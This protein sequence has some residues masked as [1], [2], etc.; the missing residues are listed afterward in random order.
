[1]SVYIMSTCDI[2]FGLYTSSLKPYFI[3]CGHTFC[4]TCLKGLVKGKI[5]TCAQCRKEFPADFSKFKVNYALINNEEVKANMPDVKAKCI[6]L[7]NDIQKLEEISSSLDR[8]EE[9]Y[10]S[11]CN[12]SENELNSCIESLVHALGNTKTQL[13]HKIEN[14]RN[15]NN[16]KLS[17]IKK[18]NQ[19]SI[20]TR[21]KVLKALMESE[22][23]RAP[24]DS[25][26]TIDLNI[27]KDI[28]PISLNLQKVEYD[29]LITLMSSN[30]SENLTKNLVIS[31]VQLLLGVGVNRNEYQSSIIRTDIEDRGSSYAPSN[32][33]DNFRPNWA[34]MSES[35]SNSNQDLRAQRGNRRYGRG[36][37]NNRRP[38]GS[39]INEGGHSD[40]GS[41]QN[42]DEVENQSDI[43]APDSRRV[44]NQRYRGRHSEPRGNYRGTNE[45][46]GYHEQRGYHEPRGHH[47]SRGRPESRG[48][49]VVEENKIQIPP[50]AFDEVPEE[51]AEHIWFIRLGP[52]Q[53]RLP[54]WVCSQINRFGKKHKVVRI[55]KDNKVVNI[56]DLNNMK[57]F[58]V[59]EMGQKSGHVHDLIGN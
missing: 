13:L 48:Q 45:P 39:N 7:Q 40:A 17:Q 34:D 18:D 28:K 53:R 4:E 8:T 51:N 35:S 58:Q 31:E 23:I 16:R 54:N 1:M 36:R 38:R 33:V 50:R 27:L 19:S 43:S 56:A 21:R 22:R 15:S 59:D 57:Y 3:P 44:N 12:A 55:L 46:R 49:I 41:V 5:L 52:E 11:L 6:Q 20:A 25:S 14:I 37:F 2:C 47:G 26:T 10:Q 42:A 9:E 32:N 24:L 30:I 29:H